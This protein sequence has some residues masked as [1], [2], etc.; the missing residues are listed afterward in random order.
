MKNLHPAVW[1]L[2]AATA[3]V[4]FW[5]QYGAVILPHLDGK[6]AQII[7]ALVALVA[8]LSPNKK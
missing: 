6:S 2:T 8:A 1:L 3:F 5:S 7:T 4:T